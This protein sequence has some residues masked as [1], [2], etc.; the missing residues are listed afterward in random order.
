[1]SA[2][3]FYGATLTLGGRVAEPLLSGAS[4]PPGHFEFPA[5]IR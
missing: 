1:M 4:S 2:G 3:F 5:K